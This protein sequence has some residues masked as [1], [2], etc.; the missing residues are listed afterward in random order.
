MHA[1]SEKTIKSATDEFGVGSCN[2][3]TMFG[4]CNF[5]FAVCI[6]QFLNAEGASTEEKYVSAL[7][8]IVRNLFK[9]QSYLCCLKIDDD[10]N[11]HW[12]I[13]TGETWKSLEKS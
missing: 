3:V 7:K 1:P 2:I 13:I 12:R 10:N 4:F 6:L 11:N 8:R 9:I 5:L